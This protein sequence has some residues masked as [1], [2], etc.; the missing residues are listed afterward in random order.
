MNLIRAVRNIASDMKLNRQAR[1][2]FRGLCDEGRAPLVYVEI[3][4]VT[5]RGD[6]WS[7]MTVRG[8][9]GIK[10]TTLL[11]PAGEKSIAADARTIRRTC[12]REVRAAIEASAAKPN[13]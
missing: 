3:R 2:E 11:S 1:R 4:L 8:I 9:T 6:D 10:R 5:D 7:G 12:I 13:R